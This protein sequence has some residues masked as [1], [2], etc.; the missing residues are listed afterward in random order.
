MKKTLKFASFAITI[1]IVISILLFKNFNTN[2]NIDDYLSKGYTEEEIMLF[3]DIGFDNNRIYKWRENIKVEIKD[4]NKLN[5]RQINDVDSIISIIGQL[6]SPIK[7]SRVEKDGNLKIHRKPETLP[8]TKYRDARGLTIYRG[9]PHIKKA[10]IYILK[11]LSEQ[12]ATSVLVHEFLHAIGLSH[13]T[14]QYDFHTAI[15]TYKSPNIFNS[16]DDYE[17]HAENKY[18]ISEQEKQVIRM[19]YSPEIKVGLKKSKFMKKM[20][21][22]N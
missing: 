5:Q 16:I 1:I 6:I 19:L 2:F 18:F 14:N 21:I 17:K 8:G 11:E 22:N 9:K 15:A 13:A 20:K 4:I 12:N 3:S 10:E 7:I